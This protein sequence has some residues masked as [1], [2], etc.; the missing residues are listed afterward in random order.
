M[1]VCPSYLWLRG[2]FRFCG[3]LFFARRCVR[4]ANR[5]PLISF[6]FDDFPRSALYSGGEVLQEHGLAATYYA[7]LGLMSQ[8]SPVGRIFSE[9]DLHET[10]ARGHELGCHTFDHC[11]AWNTHPKVF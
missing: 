2:Y 8:E 1:S 6:T 9:E 4:L 7:A 3:T 11:H 10:L 5:T